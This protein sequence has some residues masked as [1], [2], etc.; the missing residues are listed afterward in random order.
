MAI[1]ALLSFNGAGAF[2]ELGKAFDVVV[3]DLC[4]T[5]LANAHANLG[6]QYP[7]VEATLHAN[8]LSLAQS[9][10]IDGLIG[11]FHWKAFIAEW[12]SGS[13]MDRGNPDLTGYMGSE[14]WNPARNGFNITGRPAGPYLGLDGQMH[15][16]HTGALAGV[17]LEELSQSDSEFQ[18]WMARV[19]L[20]PDAFQPKI[21]LHF[22][23]YALESN[24]RLIMDQLNAVIETFSFGAFFV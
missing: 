23:R 20:P 9:G 21:P 6:G 13:D 10:L 24:R 18:A 2:D 15:D 7:E 8:L 22:M 12:G 16:D 17:N 5:V 4:Q 1:E 11:A 3:G 19:G 14:T